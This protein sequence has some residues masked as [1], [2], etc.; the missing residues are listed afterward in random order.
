MPKR[1][2]WQRILIGILLLLN[3]L[4]FSGGREIRLEFGAVFI[5]AGWGLLSWPIL[6]NVFLGPDEASERKFGLLDAIKIA[7]SACLLFWGLFSRDAVSGS[8]PAIFFAVGII[9]LFIPIEPLIKGWGS[10][11]PQELQDL[12]KLKSNGII[13]EDEYIKLKDKILK[14][15]KH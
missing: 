15:I 5:V 8:L 10:T 2:G 9:I 12:D 6:A 13:D 3:A 4:P 7:L 11:Q 1:L 14:N